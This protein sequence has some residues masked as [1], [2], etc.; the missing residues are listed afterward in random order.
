MPAELK[1][2]EMLPLTKGVRSFTFR[3]KE[4]RT[5]HK[6]P[7]AMSDEDVALFE[8][9]KP[10]HKGRYFKPIATKKKTTSKAKKDAE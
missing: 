7:E 8:A 4:G 5:V 3:T 1:K 9:Q 6:A 2:Y 10:A